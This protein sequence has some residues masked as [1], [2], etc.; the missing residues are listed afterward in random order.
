MYD[1]ELIKSFYPRVLGLDHSHIY[2]TYIH[3]N[4]D[5]MSWNLDFLFSKVPWWHSINSWYDCYQNSIIIPSLTRWGRVTHICASKLTIISSDNGL[6][7]GWRQAIVWTKTGILLV[8]SS[9]TNLNEILIETHIFSFKECIW[10]CLW[11]MMANLSRPQ[12]VDV[13]GDKYLL[14]PVLLI[15]K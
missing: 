14:D 10:K 7:P 6:S 12:Y 13:Y 4:N 2:S 3:Y 9:R 8:R 1:H 15:A 5:S 11:E